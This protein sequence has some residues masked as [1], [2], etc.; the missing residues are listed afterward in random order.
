MCL[1]TA[2]GIS[3]ESQISPQESK[4]KVKM[5]RN[6]PTEIKACRKRRQRLC[7]ASLGEN[8]MM[9]DV[10]VFFHTPLQ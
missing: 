10:Y 9:A 1:Q 4:T 6:R 3:G 8:G 2:S 7:S 5:E